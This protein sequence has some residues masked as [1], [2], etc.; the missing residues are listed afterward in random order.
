[1]ILHFNDYVPE[2]EEIR[3]FME[4]VKGHHTAHAHDFIEIVYVDSG[5]GSQ[6]INGQEILISKG[7][8]LLLNDHIAHEFFAHPENPLVVYNC[9]FQPQSVS[10]TFQKC[11]N[12]LDV[13]YHFLFHPLNSET[14]PKDYI[15]LSVAQTTEIRSVIHEMYHEYE[16]K[17]N[18]FQQV[19]K[20]DLKKL[21]ILM[22]RLY[23][24]DKNQNRNSS[25]YKQLIVQE[26]ISYLESHYK[27][28]I[29]CNKLAQRSYLSANYF[30]KIFKEITG[31]SPTQM[32]QNIRIHAACKLLLDTSL[33]VSEI[34]GLVGYSDM[35]YF[36]SLFRH[37]KAITPG[38]YRIKNRVK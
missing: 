5:V 10:H 2:D 34:A 8:L 23:Q 12:F 13:A 16:K 32:H 20:A 38:E 27:E 25:V 17:E 29:K 36:Y 11:S 31:M 30:A 3:I 15:Q 28:E 37:I 18:G 6:I 22:F 4:T 35:K 9:L 33:T 1:M 21:M 24:G 19:M 26:A 14:D 7:S